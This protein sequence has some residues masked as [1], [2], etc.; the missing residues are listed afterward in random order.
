MNDLLLFVMTGWTICAMAGYLAGK[1]VWEV[2][3]VIIN[4][5][6]RNI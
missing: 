3:K 2:S 1:I 6:R 4:W 5:I